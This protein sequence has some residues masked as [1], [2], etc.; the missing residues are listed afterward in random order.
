MAS[1]AIIQL[2]AF[3]FSLEKIFFFG[4]LLVKKNDIIFQTNDVFT[5]ILI[6]FY[7]D[8]FD[9]AGIFTFILL[10]TVVPVFVLG[11]SFGKVV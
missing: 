2:L 3:F 7:S 8:I 10:P 11:M 4:V 1:P 6:I 9:K 5:C